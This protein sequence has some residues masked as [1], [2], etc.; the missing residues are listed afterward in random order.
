M[1]ETVATGNTIELFDATNGHIASME[2]TITGSD[3][4]DQAIIDLRIAGTLAD[5]D[6]AAKLRLHTDGYRAN[7]ESKWASDQTGAANTSWFN[8]V[9]KDGGLGGY[10]LY[11]T[12]GTVAEE[13]ALELHWIAKAFIG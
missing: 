11:A 1:G 8:C 7:L 9:M 2:L 5:N 4:F 10:C 12:V 13:E 6:A 3:D